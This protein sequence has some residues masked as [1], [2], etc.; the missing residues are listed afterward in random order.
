MEQG[1]GEFKEYRRLILSELE[2]HE[3]KLDSIELKVNAIQ[4]E[5]T[6]LKVRV[7]LIGAGAGTVPVAGYVIFQGLLG[8][9]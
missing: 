5:L 3:D 2:R 1:N 8:G 9:G 4:G 7:S 6:A